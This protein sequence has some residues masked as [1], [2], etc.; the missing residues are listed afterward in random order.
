[1][2]EIGDYVWE[3]TNGNEVSKTLGEPG[4]PNVTLQLLDQNNNVIATTTTNSQ[5][6]YEFPNLPSREYIT[7]EFLHQMV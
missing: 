2:A 3:D 6:Y 5:G 4:V 1:M 7:Y